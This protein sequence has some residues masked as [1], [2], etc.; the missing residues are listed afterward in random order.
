MQDCA[1]HHSQ[2]E[3][4]ARH[5]QGVCH[6]A[7]WMREMYTH[8][9]KHKVSGAEEQY[10]HNVFEDGWRKRAHPV[11]KIRKSLTKETIC[12]MNHEE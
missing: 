9:P 5:G 11:G 3:G 1:K 12:E 6:L 2:S 7:M 10:K 4:L 8:K